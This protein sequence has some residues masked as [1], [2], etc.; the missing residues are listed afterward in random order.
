MWPPMARAPAAAACPPG[1]A[2]KGPDMLLQALPR[3][4]R[5][6]GVGSIARPEAMTA[7]AVPARVGR[8]GPPAT[9]ITD[10]F[11]GHDAPRGESA[12][13]APPPADAVPADAAPADLGGRAD[14]QL[15]TDEE[16]VAA[17]R[18]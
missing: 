15:L 13:P 6:A 5:A 12:V 1:V 14:V 18:A 17:H 4:R 9:R 8:F 10:L 2:P 11:G 16:L 7:S 3:P